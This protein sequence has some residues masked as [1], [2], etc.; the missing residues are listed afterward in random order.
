MSAMKLSPSRFYL[1]RTPW[2]LFIKHKEKGINAF[3][4]ALHSQNHW[5][6]T[7]SFISHFVM[8]SGVRYRLLWFLSSGFCQGNGVSFS[9]LH[10]VVRI[11]ACFLIK[12]ITL[13]SI[14]LFLLC[15]VVL[16]VLPFLDSKGVGWR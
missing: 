3:D 7:D 9:S 6:G 14:G 2:N 10:P 16:P 12:I 4:L 13:F 8:P 5:P 11:N 15:A 1:K